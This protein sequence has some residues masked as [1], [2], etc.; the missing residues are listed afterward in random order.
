MLPALALLGIWLCSLLFLVRIFRQEQALVQRSLSG[1]VQDEALMEIQLRRRTWFVHGSLG[2]IHQVRNSLLGS[3][4][5]KGTSCLLKVFFKDPFD[6]VVMPA[7]Q[8]HR[9]DERG[10]DEREEDARS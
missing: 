7:A 2:E 6:V 9:K 10:A 8:N 4:R 1:L 3:Q 5:G